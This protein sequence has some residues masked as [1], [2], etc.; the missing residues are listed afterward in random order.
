[1][2][3]TFTVKPTGGLCNY[4]RV[5]FSYWLYCK[6]TNQ[7]LVVLWIPTDECPGFFLD[8]F[9]PLEGVTFIEAFEPGIFVSYSG[10]RWHPDYN[11]YKMF[12]YDGLK[13][14]NYI[15]NEIN[16]KVDYMGHYIAVHIRR[17]D[18]S[19]LAIVNHSFTQ[20]IDFIDFIKEFPAH[21][22][23]I[24]TDNRDT[25][26][27]FVARFPLQI[28]GVPW[29]EPI[30]SLRQTTFKQAMIDLFVCIKASKFMGSGYSSFSGTIQ[31]FRQTCDSE[32]K[33]QFTIPY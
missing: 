13:P 11:P 1:M 10:N 19:D 27:D 32:G 29:I 21:N 23:Y 14:L 12:I 17:T 9:Q 7:R 2:R 26:D 18:H 22:V 5:V 3:A 25:Q 6:K 24:A 28:K 8:Y 31:Q 20:D 30:D 33:F 16:E 4:L 15:Q